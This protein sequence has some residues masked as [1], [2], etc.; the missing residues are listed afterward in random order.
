LILTADSTLL[1]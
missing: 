1:R